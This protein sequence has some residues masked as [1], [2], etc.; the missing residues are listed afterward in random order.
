MKMK[1]KNANKTHS[2]FVLLATKITNHWDEYTR[3]YKAF[4]FTSFLLRHFLIL[5]W[6][7]LPDSILSILL[8]CVIE[9]MSITG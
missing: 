1:K 5:I 3:I 4:Y 9:Y 2:Q 8:L 6:T 7:K